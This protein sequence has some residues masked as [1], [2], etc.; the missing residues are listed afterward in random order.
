LWAEGRYFPLVYSR[1]QVERET[2][3]VLQLRPAP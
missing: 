1:A 3:H 2:A